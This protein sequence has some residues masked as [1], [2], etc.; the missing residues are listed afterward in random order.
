MN[1]QLLVIIFLSL[2]FSINAQKKIAVYGELLGNGIFYASLNVE[3]NFNERYG[4]RAGLC[5]T[6]LTPFEFTVPIMGHYF[7]GENNHKLEL[8]LGILYV[9]GGIVFS[10]G[11][12]IE[13]VG[14]TS[15][16]MYRYHADSGLL[17]RMGLAPFYDNGNFLPMPSF[18]CGY[19]F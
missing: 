18:G 9:K 6:D 3:Y 7:L 11:S 10:E 17:L 2:A 12:P 1:R 14:I 13:G 16:I 8:G 19:R 15:S 4:I 5:V